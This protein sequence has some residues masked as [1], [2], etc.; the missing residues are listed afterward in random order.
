[1]GTVYNFSR[2]HEDTDVRLL[3]H[4]T[5][6]LFTA[7]SLGLTADNIP[8]NWLLQPESTET[9]RELASRKSELAQLKKTEPSFSIRC[10]DHLAGE[11]RGQA[12]AF[13]GIVSGSSLRPDRNV[14]CRS[15]MRPN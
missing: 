12:G 8:E 2:F 5:T 1:M 14:R 13:A 4:D 6:P 3:T 15:K 10:V 11:R 7:R 9:E